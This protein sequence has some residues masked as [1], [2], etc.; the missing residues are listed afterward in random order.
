MKRRD[1]LRGLGAMA[2]FG[3]CD[4]D[5]PRTGVLGAMER[6]NRGAQSLIFTPSFDSPAGELTPEDAFPGYKATPGPVFPTA[7]ADWKLAI[8]GRV[9][10]PRRLSLE[11]LRALPRTD[12][13]IEHHCVE[14]WSATA[15]WYGVRLSELAKLVGAEDVGYVQF[16][17]F[18]LGYS[19]SWDIASAMHSQTMIALGMNG[20]PLTPKHGAP[21]RLYGA[22]KLGYKQV[23][24]LTEI[25]FLD[26]ETG[27]YWEDQ[28]Y[29]WYA[30][31]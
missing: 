20:K 27:G 23:K 31:V 9:A 18:D 19:S 17:S 7:P 30:G 4:T 5:H 12:A 26:E 24:Y 15:D 10:R 2:L 11:D 16:K 8:G 6:W 1:L 29:E 14:G 28:G 25:N 22:V 21:A 3:A 13:R